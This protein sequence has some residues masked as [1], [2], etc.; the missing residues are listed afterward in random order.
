MKRVDPKVYTKDYFLNTCRGFGHFNET[1]GEDLERTMKIVSKKIPSV[2]NM[3]VLDL[4]CGR[5]E[6]SY[7][8]AKRGAKTVIGIDYSI[9]AIKL[10]NKTKEGWPKTIKDKVNF[11]LMD[12][13]KLDFLKKTFDAVISTEVFEHLYEEEEKIVLKNINYVLKD[14]GFLFIHTSPSRFFTDVTYKYW[15][16][17]VSSAI[18]KINNL[19]SGKQYP[20]IA[21]QSKLRT[22]L[23]KTVHVNEPTYFQLR[24]IF[25]EAGFKGE[26]YSSNTAYTKPNLGWKDVVFNF[27]VFLV[28]LSNF[29]PLN[30]IWG[31]DFYTVLRKS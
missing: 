23:H 26:I 24:K 4:G 16:Y 11:K 3:K 13:K 10:A 5:G 30:I 2:R 21:K 22:K 28:P 19:I 17:P 8:A 20:N 31:N 9:D 18:V 7:W 6:Y 29:P 1:M 15:S 14:N 25:N 27:L 12:A